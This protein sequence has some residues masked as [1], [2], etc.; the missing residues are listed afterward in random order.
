[1]NDLYASLE[2]YTRVPL[3][4]MKEQFPA[5]K[6]SSNDYKILSSIPLILKSGRQEDVASVFRELYSPCHGPCAP[7]SGQPFFRFPDI[8]DDP[9]AVY[10]WQASKWDAIIFT[11]SLSGRS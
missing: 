7:L 3:I 1:M 6:I 8:P 9:E 10:T 5:Y 11:C 4:L 2:V